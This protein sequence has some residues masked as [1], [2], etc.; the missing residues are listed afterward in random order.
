MAAV[1]RPF[2]LEAIG[3]A[4]GLPGAYPEAPPANRAEEHVPR[5][6]V[7]EAAI[8]PAEERRVAWI[9]DIVEPGGSPGSVP[10][11]YRL[12]IAA[13][14]TLLVDLPIETYNPYFGCDC[15]FMG[16]F[17]DRVVSIYREK[18]RMLVWSVPASGEDRRLVSIDDDH[19][20]RDGL[21]VFIGS[22]PGQLEALDLVTLAPRTPLV[23]RGSAQDGRLE[24]AG[25][26]LR[27][28][29]KSG[30]VETL[31][32]PAKEQ[33]WFP[34]NGDAFRLDV[35]RALFGGSSVPPAASLVTAAVASTFWIA[36]RIVGSD[37][38]SARSRHPDVRWLPAYWYQ[39]LVRKGAPGEAEEFLAML[40][41]MARPLSAEEPETGW[42]PSWDA[43]EGSRILATRYLRRRARVLAEV[44]RSG[45]LPAGEYCSLWN[46]IVP[47][48]LE[49]LPRPV[50]L[51]YETLKPTKPTPMQAVNRQV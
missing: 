42:D 14:G 48:E 39:H 5:R 37:Y 8:D 1:E 28:T 31:R 13:G 2:H 15:G 7:L 6:E 40:D 26:Q 33:E 12:K 29:A 44:C 22:D 38:E 17:G 10:I 32:L 23:L 18:H 25:D 20:V 4:L 50:Q 16:W 21:V 43:E 11:D 3:R 19:V 47:L 51:V 35:E 34:A 46:S 45:S 30:A 27:Y 36:R 9:E 24:L 49:R 41:T